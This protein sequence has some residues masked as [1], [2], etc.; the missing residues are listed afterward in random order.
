MI[1]FRTTFDLLSSDSNPD[2]SLVHVV[3]SWDPSD[4]L[5]VTLTFNHCIAEPVLWRISRD[6]LAAGLLGP[7]G[8]GDVVVYPVLDCLRI[9]L[10]SPAGHAEFG[11]D[12]GEIAEFL[13]RS[14]AVTPSGWEYAEIDIDAELSEW[15]GAA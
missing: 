14:F 8:V 5:A 6:T 11:A 9:I 3:L 7:S 12:P 2:P 15:I 4:P 10:D 13:G 1:T